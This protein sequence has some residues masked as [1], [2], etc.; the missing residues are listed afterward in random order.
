LNNKA[1]QQ[2]VDYSKKRFDIV[3]DE[4]S[5]AQ[6][7]KNATIKGIIAHDINDKVVLIEEA[8]KIANSW[9][10][11]QFIQTK[12]LGHGLHDE[13]LY[14]TITEFITAK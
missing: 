10:T 2:L 3:V 12:G 6:F 1:Y 5:G 13:E 8:K 7:L 11:A 4:F 14:Q 9:K